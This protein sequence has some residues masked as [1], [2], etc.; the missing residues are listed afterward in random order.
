MANSDVA[1]GLSPIMYMNG[2][3]YNG[4]ATRYYVPDTDAV[5]LFLGD[6]VRLAGSADATGKYP[7]VAKAAVGGVTIGPII[8]VEMDTQQQGGS[9]QGSPVY[10]QAS[11]ARYVLVADDPQI[12][13]EVQEDSV[14]GALVADDIGQN[15]SVIQ[16]AGSTNTGYSGAELDTST[17]AVTATLDLQ[18]LRLV[19]RPDNALGANAKVLVRLNNHQFVDGTLGI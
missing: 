2:A 10:R 19:D 17:A 18:I 13:F 8:A 6:L 16:A 12:V 7:T 11:V 3:P 15:A 5:N 14:G 9:P 4:Q 1:S